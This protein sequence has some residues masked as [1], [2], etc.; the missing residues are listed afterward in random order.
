MMF[1]DIEKREY[2][3]IFLRKIKEVN[4]KWQVQVIWRV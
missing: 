4:K 3:L 2:P 1:Y